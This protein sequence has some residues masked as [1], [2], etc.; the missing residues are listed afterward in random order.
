MHEITSPCSLHMYEERVVKMHAGTTTLKV[1]VRGAPQYDEA[2]SIFFF[3]THIEYGITFYICIGVYLPTLCLCIFPD[4]SGDLCIQCY[5]YVF[6]SVHTR[7]LHT[8]SRDVVLGS[9]QQCI[10]AHDATKNC[11]CK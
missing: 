4:A 6:Q 9:W 11:I 1:V 5:T 2:S 8:S 10:F 3:V 7:W